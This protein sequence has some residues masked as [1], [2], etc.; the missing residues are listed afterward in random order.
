M[1]SSKF[2]G[3]AGR[4]KK[5]NPK[6]SNDKKKCPYCA[7]KSHDAESCSK[8]GSTV[9]RPLTVTGGAGSGITH[10]SSRKAMKHIPPIPNEEKDEG[11]SVLLLA[12]NNNCSDSHEWWSQIVG[13]DEKDPLVV[14]DAGCD[15]GASLDS[16][17]ILW[18]AA[19]TKCLATYRSSITKF[20]G[21]GG[22]IC[23]QYL[24]LG[25]TWNPTAPH[26]HRMIAADPHVYFVIG[27]GHGYLEEISDLILEEEEEEEKSFNNSEQNVLDDNSMQDA[28]D[29]L[30]TAFD[31]DD[32]IVGFCAKLDYSLDAISRT[33]REIQLR[34]LRVTCQVASQEGTV[35]QI[36]ITDGEGTHY[37]N[38]CWKDLATILLEFTPQDD[39]PPMLV[40]LS[41]WSG[42]SDT[43][44]KLLAAYPDSLYIGL[45]PT[46]GFL[47]ATQAQ[48]CAFDVPLERV[49]LETDNII[50]SPISK[51]L[52]RKA[53]SHSA[54]VHYCILALAEQK[55]VD[56]AMVART[57]METTIRVYG[58][59]FQTR[60]QE[61]MA[62]RQLLL[63][64][65]QAAQ[66]QQPTDQ[67]HSEELEEKNYMTTMNIVEKGSLENHSNKKNKSMKKSRK[68]KLILDGAYQESTEIALDDD[69]L[70]S[71]L[72]END[73]LD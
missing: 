28:I 47:K 10:K 20:P 37:P 29:L 7:S 45:N 31:S 30:V 8:K 63:Q 58:E 9:R 1:Y 65:Q 62:E 48:E 24:K 12:G 38:Q 46:M 49:L 64:Q 27:L 72:L 36:R 5:I 68:G 15:V 57:T 66:N 73:I 52:G 51:S 40:H 19:E 35:I 71:M 39:R 21:Y 18:K 50:P 43:M 17:S 11:L 14:F 26:I 25:K 13:E 42:K 61:I 44:M 53:Y 55:K 69:I 3:R 60:R 70:S 23:R 2:G 22:A 4:S 56:P 32:R 6:Q 67:V 41:S 34:R 59:R 16:L 33:S 54:Q